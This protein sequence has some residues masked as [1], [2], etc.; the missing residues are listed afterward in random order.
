MP[1]PNRSLWKVYVVNPKGS[2]T[3][4]LDG[5]SVVAATEAEAREKVGVGKVIA[6]AGL[7][8]D[9]ADV[10]AEKVAEF[11]RP[12]KETQRVVLAKDQDSE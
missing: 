5:I 10:Y 7:D 6:S 4:L 9:Q 1:N 3:V 2:G 8:Y 11:V 12:R